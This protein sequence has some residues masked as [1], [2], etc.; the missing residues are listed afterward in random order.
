MELILIAP[1]KRLSQLRSHA[2]D[3]KYSPR[4]AC[5]VSELILVSWTLRLRADSFSELNVMELRTT[6]LVRHVIAIALDKRFSN[7]LAGHCTGFGVP[8]GSE[9]QRARPKRYFWR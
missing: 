1:S 6:A 4:S 9:I 7:R 2:R 5:R 3:T 8:T